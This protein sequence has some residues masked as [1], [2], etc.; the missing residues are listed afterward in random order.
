M[1]HFIQINKFRSVWLIFCIY[2]DL[3]WLI[4][5]GSVTWYW[6]IYVCRLLVDL[7]WYFT[8]DF[9]A[10]RYILI[11]FVRS[12][13][14]LN[15]F[16][17]WLA[18]NF[19]LPNHLSHFNLTLIHLFISSELNWTCWSVTLNHLSLFC[20]ALIHFGQSRLM[21]NQ[22]DPFWLI[23]SHCGHSRWYWITQ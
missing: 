17:F 14:M 19:G 15:Y 8:F 7:F 16:L 18:L 20:S 21:L 22:L 13:L 23:L 3:S 1:I 5:C 11:H 12:H 4:L 6:F 10:F 9:E 2:F